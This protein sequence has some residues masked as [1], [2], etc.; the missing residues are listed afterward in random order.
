MNIEE[1][2]FAAA[3]ATSAASAH[4]KTTSRFVALAFNTGPH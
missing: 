1:L 2:A 4:A 3:G